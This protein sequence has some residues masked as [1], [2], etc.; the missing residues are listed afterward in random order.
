MGQRTRQ[1]RQHSR[2]RIVTHGADRFLAV[3]HQCVQQ[4]V[5]VLAAE[6]GGDLAADQGIAG[7]GARLGPRTD[8][9]LQIDHVADPVLVRMGGGQCI[10]GLVLVI[11]AGGLQ[12]D[13]DQLART[14]VQTTLHA[15]FRQRHQTGFGACQQKTVYGFDGTQRSQAVAALQ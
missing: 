5:A 9:R 11:D 3:A 12:I 6:T 10:D 2:R 7:R 13:G 4:Q 14:D 8:Q 15:A 1:R